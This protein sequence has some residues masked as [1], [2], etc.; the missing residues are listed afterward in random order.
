MSLD[1]L[2]NRLDSDESI[3]FTRQLEYIFQKTY[4]EP[5]ADL[6]FA[7]LLP[8]SNE[9]PEWATEGTWRSYRMF[10]QAKII[11]DYAKDYPRAGIGGTEHTFKVKDI[12]A[13]YGYTIPEIKRA[14]KAGL[15]L[16]Q[17]K[18]TAARRAIEQKL[19][20]LAWFGDSTHGL[21][22]FFKYPGTQEYVVPATGTGTSKLWSKKTPDQIL[23][24]LNGIV[25]QIVTTT[26]G[27]ERPD[28]ILLPW[29]LLSLIKNTRVGTYS[30][31]T[32]FK[33]FTDNNPDISIEALPELENA[34]TGGTIDLAIAYKKDPDHVTFQVP[35]AFTQ[36]EADKEGMEYTI[37]CMGRCAG[38]Q[39]Y[40]PLSVAWMEGI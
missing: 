15:D 38:V 3:F 29:T 4:D 18:A 20:T 37:P 12:G 34:G 8:V 9:I 11:A 24:D 17:R 39:V 19:N 28:T 25:T 13:A 6:K 22:G 33:F 27:K 31:A 23:T 26:K 14:A 30:D 7:Q 40:Y 32:I 1:M 21:Q 16:V 2:S 36:G 10:A 5:L 35:L